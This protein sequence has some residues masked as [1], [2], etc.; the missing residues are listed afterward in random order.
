MFDEVSGEDG[1]GIVHEQGLTSFDDEIPTDVSTGDRVELQ[2][3]GAG[4]WAEVTVSNGH[5]LEGL[6]LDALE[7]SNGTTIEIGDELQFNLSN[8]A[9]CKHSG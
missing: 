5:N 2:I 1:S 3:N 6:S 9:R 8:I 7:A 4:L